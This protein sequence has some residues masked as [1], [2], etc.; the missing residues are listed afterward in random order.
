MSGDQVF[1]LGAALLLLAVALRSSMAAAS[2]DSSL[3]DLQAIGETI[4]EALDPIGVLVKTNYISLWADAIEQFESGGNPNALNYRNNNPGNLRDP[5]TG[6]FR[7][8][9]SYEEGRAALIADLTAKV[10]KYPNFTVL[11]IMTRYLGGDPQNPAI[12]GEG[13]PFAYAQAIAEK[14]GVTTDTLIGSFA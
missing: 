8:F 11:Q 1:V 3:P 6:Q 14:L 10:R 4:A 5:L 9:A 13:D 7:V 2:S 12:T